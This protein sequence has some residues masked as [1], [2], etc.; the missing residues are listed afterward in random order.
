MRL[1]IQFQHDKRPALDI[2]VRAFRDDPVMNWISA[3]PDFLP[4]FFDITLPVFLPHDLTYIE[5]QGRGAA[6]WLGPGQKLH[7]PVTPGNLW[8]MLKVCGLRGFYRFARSGLLATA[9]FHPGEPHYYLFLIGTL[10]EC[11]GQGIGSALMAQVLRQ[12]DEEN[13]PAYLENSKPDNLAFYRGHGFE[14]V[15]RIRFTRS[16]PPVWLMWREPRPAL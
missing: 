13:L 2:F 9:K 5:E 8:R 11:K 7:W 1:G 3:D 12:C 15:D 14:V 4:T 10:P 6:A 16:A